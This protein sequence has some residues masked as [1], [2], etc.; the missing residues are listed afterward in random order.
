MGIVVVVRPA[1]SVGV[2]R[3]GDGVFEMEGNETAR[4]REIVWWEQA[5]RVVKFRSFERVVAAT[6]DLRLNFNCVPFDSLIRTG[7]LRPPGHQGRCSSIS[8]ACMGRQKSL[9]RPSAPGPSIMGR[10]VKATLQE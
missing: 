8:G 7:C 1:H 5:K 9:G 2:A 10:V 4:E 6:P 3:C